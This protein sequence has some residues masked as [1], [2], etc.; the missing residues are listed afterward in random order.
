M[1]IEARFNHTCVHFAQSTDT[2][3]VVSL[4]APVVN[5]SVVRP[6]LAIVVCVDTSG[7]MGGQKLEYAKLSIEKLIEHL[8]PEDYLG[9]VEFNGSARALSKPVKMTAAKKDDLR[10]SV[11]ALQARGGT[12]FAGGMLQAIDQLK[13]L[14]LGVNYIHRIIMFTDGQPNQGPAIAPTDIVKFFK[15]NAPD[16][17]TAS[18]FGYGAGQDFDPDFLATFA[19]EAKGNY[20]HVENPDNAL[21][22][23]GIELGGL[24]STYATNIRVCVTPLSGH[25]IQKVVSDVDIEPS[26]DNSTWITISDLLAEETRDIVFDVKLSEQ[27]AHGPRAVNAFETKVFFDTFDTTGKKSSET[28]EAKAKIRFVKAGEEVKDTKLDNIIGLAVLART[29]KEAEEAAKKGDF[30]AAQA[31]FRNT[32]DAFRVAGNE[33]LSVAALGLSGRLESADSYQA[34]QGYLRSLSRGI[35][36]GMGGSYTAEVGATLDSLGVQVQNSVQTSTSGSFSVASGA[37]IVAGATPSVGLIAGGDI[38]GAVVSGNSILGS[39]TGA[40]SSAAFVVPGLTDVDLEA[41]PV[42]SETDKS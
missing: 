30:A 4:T 2:N 14:D 10:R 26:E 17:I 7:S 29:Q 1:K 28:K 40:A 8:K 27:K 42:E 25:S 16:H 23:F 35:T 34:N 24:M 21:Q 18:A 11:R 6:K 20:A 31:A 22:A 3:L 13:D 5:T 37:S 12:N 32:A 41:P 19:R 38:G 36:R 33:A 9:I 15:A 39:F